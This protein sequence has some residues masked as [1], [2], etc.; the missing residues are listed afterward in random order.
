LF[1]FRIVLCIYLLCGLCYWLVIAYGVL[2]LRSL[3]NLSKL[4]LSDPQRWPRLSVIIPACNEG[5]KIESAVRTVLAD[6]Y[7]DLD[8]VLVD[9]RSTDTT[10]QCIDRL[11][12]EDRRITAIHITDLPEGWLGKVNA[13][14]RGLSVS[15]GD[16]VL[17]TDAD[18]HF[19]PCTLQ[20]AVAYCLQHNIDHLVACPSVWP[21]N[22]L[23]DS[24]VAAFLRQFFTLILPPW[25]INNPSP[26]AFFGVGAFNLVRRSKFE[27]TEGF[28]WLRLETADDAGL[29]LLMKRSAAKSAVVTA[30]DRIG[31]QWYRTVGEMARGAEKGYASAGKCSFVRMLVLGLAGMFLEISP[32]IGLLYS[33][34]GTLQAGV[35]TGGLVLLFFV[36]SAAAFANWANGGMLPALLTPIT[37][38]FSAGL[39]IRAGWVGWRRGGVIWRGTLYPAELLKNK[40]RVNVGL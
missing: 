32:L 29:G 11:A 8:V 27:M 13:L 16:F 4:N 20:K 31:L 37:A 17:F 40:G 36:F 26:G 24:M 2:R 7:P 9:D 28:E 19:Q 3:P 14:N 10:G 38:F 1:I 6:G 5:D 23:V 30:F 22:L 33:V 39:A 25:R 15:R 34:F 35:I 21:A 12:A 18:V